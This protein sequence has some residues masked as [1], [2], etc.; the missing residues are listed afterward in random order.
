MYVEVLFFY[1]NHFFCVFLLKNLDYSEYFSYL[2]RL[3]ESLYSYE[4]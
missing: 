2:C 3:N 1:K 4:L